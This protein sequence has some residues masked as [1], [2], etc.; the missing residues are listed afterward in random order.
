MTEKNDVKTTIEN[1][2]AEDVTP[3]KKQLTKKTKIIISIVSI[4]IVLAIIISSCFIWQ[5]SQAIKLIA[6]T[7]TIEYGEIYTPNLKDFVEEKNIKNYS[8]DGN[9]PNEEGKEY[10]AIGEYKL[11]VKKNKESQEVVLKVK[12]TVAPTFAE[13]I[14]TTISTVVNTPLDDVTD[15]YKDKV[16]DLDDIKV[17]VNGANINYGVVGE[18]KSELIATDESGNTSKKQITVTVTENNG[19]ENPET[20]TETSESSSNNNN[21]TPPNKN[22]VN[23]SNNS[24]KTSSNT[25]SKPNK[26]SNNGSSKPSSGNSGTSSKPTT[27]PSGGNGGSNSGES[28][29]T[30]PTHCTTNSNHSIKCGNM[31]RWF[32]SKKEVERYWEQTDEKYFQQYEN[33]E[34]TYDEYAKKSPYGYKCWS[35]S[36]CGKWTGDFKSR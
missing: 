4:V 16:T 10:P 5:N 27:K 7:K 28:T 22:Q 21:T 29:T 32:N 33:G 18:Y 15:Q 12:D 8:I 13:D 25:S 31:G 24:N 36:Y 14:V 23:S 9:I 30:K 17:T 11:I 2:V 1:S 26:P 19:T 3:E 6:N 20:V 34:I 35:C